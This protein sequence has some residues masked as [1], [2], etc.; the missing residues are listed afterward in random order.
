VNWV[1]VGDS[2][3][4][5]SHRTRNT[6]CQDEVRYR[7]FGPAKDWLVVAAADGAGS[8][9]HSE[10]GA[11]LVCDE[12]VKRAQLCATAPTFSREWAVELFGAV[13]N[14]V[15]AE[16]ERREVRPREL[17]CTALLAIVGPDRAAFM[18]LGD[19]AIVLGDGSGYWPEPAGYANTT[20]FLT[21]NRFAEVIQFTLVDTPIVELAVL[22]DG[23]QRLALDFSARTPHLP[24]FRPLFSRLVSEPAP[25]SLLE[26]FRAFL[27]SAVVNA[28]TDDD[29]SLVLAVRRP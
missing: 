14:E 5:T 3:T 23:L 4:G 24:F 26:P 8:S 20:D 16:A 17:A 18:Q 13:R 9:A 2:V 27:D 15:V 22:T 25:E 19:G 7:T 10:L 6:P 12:L 11:R 29:K 21:D 28:K 1:V